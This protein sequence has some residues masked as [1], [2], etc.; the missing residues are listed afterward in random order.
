MVTRTTYVDGSENKIVGVRI[1]EVEYTSD[2]TIF[3]I[4]ELQAF[5]A[6]LKMKYKGKTVWES[7]K[8]VWN[9][10]PEKEIICDDMPKY[11]NLTEEQNMQNNGFIKQYDCG[12]HVFVW[13]KQ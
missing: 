12:N 6:E 2:G 4:N 7:A 11:E 8:I 1:T 10:H 3:N 13:E 9:L 5:I